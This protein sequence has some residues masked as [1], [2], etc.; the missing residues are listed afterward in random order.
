MTKISLIKKDLL[1]KKEKKELEQGL[2]EPRGGHV[3]GW[4]R[5]S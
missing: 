2:A 3:S 4:S 1:K 5:F